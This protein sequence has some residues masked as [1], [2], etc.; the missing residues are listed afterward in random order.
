LFWGANWTPRPK[1]IF[2]AEVDRALSQ[3][4]WVCDGNYSFLKHLIWPRMDAVIWLDYAFPLVMWRVTKRTLNNL[5]HRKAIFNNNYDSWQR[6]F[7]SK[8]SVIWYSLTSFHR[9][10]RKYLSLWGSPAFS[11]AARVWLHSPQEAEA[12]LCQFAS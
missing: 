6:A 8:D 11:Q 12:W 5:I 4:T 9:R 2:I 10:R 7:L 1:D 3:P